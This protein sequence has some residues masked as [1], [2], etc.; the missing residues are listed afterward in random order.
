MNPFSYQCHCGAPIGVPCAP[1]GSTC[2]GRG[3]PVVS[4]FRA[5]ARAAIEARPTEDNEDATGP[6]DVA[7][8]ERN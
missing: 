7:K 1:D 3:N 6:R 4:L 2:V 5:M 8:K